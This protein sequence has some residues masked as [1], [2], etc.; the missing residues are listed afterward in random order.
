MKSEIFRFVFFFFLLSLIVSFISQYRTQDKSYLNADVGFYEDSLPKEN[1]IFSYFYF[2]R[3]L[4]FEGGGKTDAGENVY[5]HIAKRLLPT[6]HLASFGVLFGAFFS[7]GLSI[8]SLYYRSDPFRMILVSISNLILSTPVFVVGV[9]LLLV[10]FYQLELFPPGGYES[11]NTYYV[12]L[13]GVTLGSRVFA[14]QTLYFIDEVWKEASSSYVTLLKTRSYPWSHIVFKEIF[15]KVLPISLV[16]LVLDFGS[17]LSGAMVV[18]E[19]FFFPGIGKSLYY[20]IK[21]MDQK[22]LSSLLLYTGVLFYVLNR[23]TLIAQKRLSGDS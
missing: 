17:L 9:L 6:F 23:I 3:D 16:I 5:S 13:P 10:F 7:M 2:L 4:I 19:I 22:L 11:F 14:R 15:L 1:Y 8:L 20:S 18:E 21:S 12:V